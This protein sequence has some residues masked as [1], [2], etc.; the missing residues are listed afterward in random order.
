MKSISTLMVVLAA[1]A[2]IGTAQAQV[3]VNRTFGMPLQVDGSVTATGCNNRGG[4]EVTLEGELH[5]GGLQMQLIL[6]NNVRGTHTASVTS[7][8]VVVLALG[9]SI[10]IPKQP[11]RGGAGG[12][13][14]ILIQFHNGNG[15]D[16]T[17]EIYLGRC[18]QG[19]SVS[20]EL[21]Y[22]VIAAAE[23]AASDCSNSGGPWITLGGS[24][25]FSGLHAR[26]IFRNNL[27]G[28]HEADVERDVTLIA[29][30][31][32]VS[33]PKQPVRGGAGGNPL[34]YFQFLQGDG[35]PIGT[36]VKLGRCNQI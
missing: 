28:T 21:L 26:I 32:K 13:P 4:P 9:E 19:L 33:I 22:Q 15:K 3:T 7:T 35:T 1:A 6:Q 27:Q 31:T 36:P 17:E 20:P 23:I 2:A 5:L 10:T 8:S 12:N 29:R 11:V 34:I 18:V 30:G 24:L 25:T 16:L 14:H